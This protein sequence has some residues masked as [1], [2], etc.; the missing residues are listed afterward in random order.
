M[1]IINQ[2]NQQ[3][4]LGTIIKG[5][6]A[7]AVATFVMDRVTQFVYERQDTGTKLRE[8][9]ARV[10]G[11]DPG[12]ALVNKLA[13]SANID[14][15]LGQPHPAGVG[16]HYGV[17]ILPAVG[18]NFLR[19]RVAWVGKDKGVLFGLASFAIINELIPPLIGVANKPTVYPWQSHAR[20]LAGHLVFGLTAHGV[21]ELLD[22]GNE[23]GRELKR[24]LSEEGTPLSNEDQIRE[25]QRSTPFMERRSPSNS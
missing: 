20:G 19:K 4:V 12:H 10:E 2:S 9:F 16:L 6:V 11:K 14:V 13:R 24:K 3:G 21:L 5:V 18:Y 7:G 1:A 23:K 15:H 22:R 17:G 25:D 8:V